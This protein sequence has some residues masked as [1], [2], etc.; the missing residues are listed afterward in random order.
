[1]GVK[2][3]K[4]SLNFLKLLFYEKADGKWTNELKETLKIRKEQSILST[5]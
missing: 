4:L 5:T 1:M 3:T 2:V